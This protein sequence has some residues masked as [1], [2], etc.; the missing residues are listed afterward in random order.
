MRVALVGAEFEENLAVRYLW[1][2]LEA[3]GQRVTQVV[4][5]D[6]DETEA[7]ARALAESGAELAGF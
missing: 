7:A 2:A 6:V 5:N 1:G 4:F 3:A